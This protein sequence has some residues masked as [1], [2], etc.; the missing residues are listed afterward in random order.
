MEDSDEVKKD[1]NF[2]GSCS[3]EDLP[4]PYRGKKPQSPD[5]EAGNAPKEPTPVSLH[6]VKLHRK[7]SDSTDS[8]TV[9]ENYEVHSLA[10]S[11][12]DQ[13]T[14]VPYV[15]LSNLYQQRR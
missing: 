15:L 7:L 12:E 1:H 5:L 3:D 6:E 2:F 10:S 13:L 11:I 14:C 4:Q 8:S 9:D